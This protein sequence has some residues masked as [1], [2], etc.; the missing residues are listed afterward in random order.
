MIKKCIAFLN[1]NTSVWKSYQVIHEDYDAIVKNEK[2]LA[3]TEKA[4]SDNQTEG[5]VAQKRQEI[6]ILGKAI[7]RLS[8]SLSHLAKKTNNQVLLKIVDVSESGYIAGDEKELMSKYKAVLEAARTNLKALAQYSI[9]AAGLDLLD[10]QL[11]SLVALPETIGIVAGIR[12]SATRSIKEL[13]TEARVIF[14][15]LDDVLEAVITDEKFLE[16]WFDE[17]KIKGRH[18]AAKKGNG[19]APENVPPVK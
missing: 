10:V 7:Y 11:K 1:A 19:S 14:D 15:R 17:R 12:K 13:N 5:H 4:Q 3:D 9:T 6:L 18:R 8:C 2:E 16:G